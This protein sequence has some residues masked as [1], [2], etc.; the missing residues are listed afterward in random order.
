MKLIG[1][2]NMRLCFNIPINSHEIEKCMHY[3]I[4]V[5]KEKIIQIGTNISLKQLWLSVWSMV[6][7]DGEEANV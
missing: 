3:L 6:G 2:V 7:S 1:G 5:Q 4:C